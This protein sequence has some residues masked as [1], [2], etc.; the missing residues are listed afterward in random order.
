MRHGF[1]LRHFYHRKPSREDLLKHLRWDL[2]LPPPPEDLLNA[3][4]PAQEE[5]DRE[6]EMALPALL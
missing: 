6:P 4:L 2:E 1:K 3:L 5:A